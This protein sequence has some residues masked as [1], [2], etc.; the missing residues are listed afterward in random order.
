M[1]NESADAQAN[2]TAAIKIAEQHALQ[3]LNALMPV[4]IDPETPLRMVKALKEMTGGYEL[5]P[6]DILSKQFKG[7]DGIVL[8]RDIRFSS[9]CEHHILPFTGTAT[10]GYIPN[11]KTQRIVGLSKLARVTEAHARRLQTQ[12]RLTMN[13]AYDLDLALNTEAVGVIVKGKHQCMGC[14]GV[15][16][17]NAEMITSTMLGLFRN[18]S[19]ARSEFINLANQR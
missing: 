18:D 19:D 16:Q 10:V 17:P 13:I 8:L 15:K 3:L 1:E 9:V 12:E 4:G 5:N 7:A 11:S 2:D 14:R 6:L